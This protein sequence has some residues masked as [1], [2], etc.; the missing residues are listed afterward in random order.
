MGYGRCVI[1]IRGDAD[2]VQPCPIKASNYAMNV[3]PEREAVTQKYPL[4]AN[5]RY[6]KKALHDR[7]KHVLSPDHPS[8]KQS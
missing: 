4:Y 2:T 7:P 1:G 5:N 6:R 8:V 3:G